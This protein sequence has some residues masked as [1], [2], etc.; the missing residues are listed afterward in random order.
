PPADTAVLELVGQ[1]TLIEPPEL[2]LGDDLAHVTQDEAADRLRETAQENAQ[3]SV[4]LVARA[5]KSDR[6]QAAR[7][8]FHAFGVAEAHGPLAA[9]ERVPVLVLDRAF[10]ELADRGRGS[11]RAQIGEDMLE[12]DPRGHLAFGATKPVLREDALLLEREPVHQ[13]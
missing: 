11:E 13:A 3:Q 7:S 6:L 5:A 2:R 9:P 4:L 8:R 12:A 1:M 10:S